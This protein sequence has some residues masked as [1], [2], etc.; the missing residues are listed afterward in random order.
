MGTFGNSLQSSG[1]NQ[2][3]LVRTNPAL[4]TDET[5]EEA[6]IVLDDGLGCVRGI[7]FAMLFNV[8]FALTIAGAWEAW[9]L[10]R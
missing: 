6:S 4:R 9:R 7:A 2:I 5:A 1:L 8:V 10:L 3:T